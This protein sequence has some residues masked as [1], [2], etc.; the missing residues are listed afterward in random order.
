MKGG[1]KKFPPSIRG[2][3]QVV[4]CLEGMAQQV[5]DPRFS[6]FVA[7]RPVINDQSLVI[8][9]HI[10]CSRKVLVGTRAD[11]AVNGYWAIAWVRAVFW[12]SK[13]DFYYVLRE[14]IVSLICNQ[15]HEC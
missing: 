10:T 11:L 5:P 4:P 15:E 2:V 13:F 12:E 7:P 3:Q 1:R 6:H 14:G 8:T 9:T